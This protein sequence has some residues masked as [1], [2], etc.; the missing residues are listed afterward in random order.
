MPVNGTLEEILK[1]AVEA[2]ASDVHLTVG[3]SPRM[4]VRGKLVEMDLP[5]LQPTDTL[6]V[7]VGIMEDV[8]RQQFEDRGEYDMALSV[9]EEIR[10]RVNAYKQ[11][12]NVSL[13]FRLITPRVP[14]L[15][16][17]GAPESVHQLAGL[18]KGLVLVTGPVGSGKTTTLAAIV[19]QINKSREAH[20]ITLESPIEYLHVHGLSIVDQRE[21]G[22]DS[23]SYGQALRSA[24]RED[25]D[26]IMV[27]ELSDGDTVCAALDAAEA[28]CLIFTA[29]A[30]SGANGALDYLLNRFPDGQQQQIRG[31][32]AGVLQSV[33]VQRLVPREDGSRGLSYEVLRVTD[34][35]RASLRG[36]KG[37]SAAA[38]TVRKTT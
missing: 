28:G 38:Q 36:A 25:P 9:S 26:V 24:L 10:C 14:S 11:R 30:A 4:R 16:S 6:D 2:D 27:G 34:A 31:R 20:V 29:V 12:G 7:L 13:A 35:T 1:M 37:G 5:R 15:E 22:L 18:Q 8:Q 17:L 33:V 32:L 21:I 23:R 3:A 19:D